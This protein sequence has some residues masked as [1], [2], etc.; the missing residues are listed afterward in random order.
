MYHCR[1]F[2]NCRKPGDAGSRQAASFRQSFSGAF[3]APLVRVTVKIEIMLGAEGN[4]IKVIGRLRAE[5]LPELK[6]RIE[7]SGGRTALDMDE[8]TLVDVESVRFLSICETQ[9]VE[10]RRCPAYIREWIARE[11]EQKC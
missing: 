8:V 11:R 6:G 5:Y 10:L 7:T 4:I 3:V 2:G 9:G 1:E